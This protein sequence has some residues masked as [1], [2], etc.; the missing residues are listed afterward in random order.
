MVSGYRTDHS[1]TILKLKFNNNKRG[2]GYWKFNNSLLKGNE[3]IQI[4]KKAIEEVKNTY[5]IIDVQQDREF[6]NNNNNNII[7]ND[8]N[9]NNNNDNNN[10]INNN[11]KNNNNNNINYN[12][13]DDIENTYSINDQ[14]LLEMILLAIRGEKIKYNSRKKEKI[15]NKKRN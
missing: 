5:K 12:N 9:N 6:N 3:Y 15:L 7:I 14:L 4:V 8:N 11:S 2:K 1:G 13:N 10:I